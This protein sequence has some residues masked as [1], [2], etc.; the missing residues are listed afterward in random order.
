M[1]NVGVL[2]DPLGKVGDLGKQVG[3]GV[4]DEAGKIEKTAKQQV[5]LEKQAEI[6]GKNADNAQGQVPNLPSSPD[7]REIVKKMYEASNI[8]TK[9]P[10]DKIIAAVIDENPKKTPD[11]IQKMAAARQQLWQQQHMSTYFEPTFNPSKKQEEPR[12]T[13]QIEKEKQEEK[14]MEALEL[15]KEEKK[16]EELSPAVKQGTV[17]R[18]PGASG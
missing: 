10:S 1:S 3:K 15:Q 8:K 5:G 13:E 11:E 6:D 12:P 16:K 4:G 9:A 17:E 18:N 14:Q 7:T 2:A